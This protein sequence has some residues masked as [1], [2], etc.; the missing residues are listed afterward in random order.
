MLDSR[1]ELPPRQRSPEIDANLRRLRY[2]L[3]KARIE[4]RRKK[5][6]SIMFLM[7]IRTT[8]YFSDVGYKFQTWR[9][10][11]MLQERVF[12]GLCGGPSC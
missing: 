6:T 8:P 10:G 1:I 3:L 7:K 11:H 9:F 12:R 4:L 5:Q 2:R